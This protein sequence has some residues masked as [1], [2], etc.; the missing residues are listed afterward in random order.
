MT[1]RRTQVVLR[2]LMM[3]LKLLEYN[4]NNYDIVVTDIEIFRR[5]ERIYII[6]FTMMNS[7]IIG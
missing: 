1:L 7:E 3:L 6:F 2:L 4:E 5:P